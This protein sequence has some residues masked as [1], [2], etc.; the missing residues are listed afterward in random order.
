MLNV[1]VC[2][3][4]KNTLIQ[5]EEQLFCKNCKQIFFINNEI[6]DFLKNQQSHLQQNDFGELNEFLTLSR[7][8]GWRNA[9][10]EINIKY[11]D[12]YDNILNYARIDWIF[13]CLDFSK[14]NTCLDIGSG[15]GTSAFSLAVYFDEV[16]SLENQKQKME[17]QRIRQE[18]DK[19]KNVMFIRADCLHLPFPENYFNLVALSD[20]FD[21]LEINNNINFKDIQINM[22]KE[23][24]KILK[25]DGCLFLGKNNLFAFPFTN[26]WLQ[27][28][29]QFLIKDDKEKW[30]NYNKNLHSFWGYKKILKEAGFNNVEIYWTLNHNIPKFAG[31][32]DKESYHFFLNWNEKN[33]NLTNNHSIF[34]SIIAHSPRSILKFALPFICPSFLIFAYKKYKGNSFESRLLEA[35]K[36]TSSFVRISG[37]LGV[38]SK[39]IYLLL[40]NGEPLSILK[41]PRFKENKQLF[42]E[43]E[44]MSQFNQLTAQKNNIGSTIIFIEPYIR[45]KPFKLDNFFYHKII[46]SWLLDFQNK[47]Q[48]GFWDYSKLETK[49]VI[50]K[51]LLLNIPIDKKIRLRTEQRLNLLLNSL[52][53]LKIKKNAEHGDF[54]PA[55][56]IIDYNNKVYVMDWEFYEDEGDPL[57]DFVVYI[58][59]C[60]SFGNFPYSFRRN[61]T[62]RGKNSF[63][64]KDIIVNYSKAKGI[65]LEVVYQS[66]PYVILRLIHRVVYSQESKHIY[67]EHYIFLLKLWD[68]MFSVSE[69]K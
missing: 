11:P 7:I 69:F 36:P 20:S 39:I 5:K 49:I 15:W 25:P 19:I 53:K 61:F 62:N 67:I 33:K 18:Q 10:R 50:L 28:S 57:F 56:I 51:N 6:F 66:V 3:K 30:K 2:P 65:P 40:N 17:F 55:N 24:Q 29:T 16:W 1:L 4:C 13:H 41:F 27:K 42:L 48:Q 45:A 58:L 44:K 38:Q 68:E 9:V 47:T 32:L 26:F 52:K 63:I 37:S 12:I 22:F 54:T 46:L 59:A 23:I 8:K 34:D 43:E 31:K 60:A 64:L 21:W 35:K 14:T